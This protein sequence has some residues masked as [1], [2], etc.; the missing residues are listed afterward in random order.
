MYYAR[1]QYGNRWDLKAHPRKELLEKLGYK[2]ASKMYRDLEGG[3]TS[4]VGY[5]IGPHWVDVH[6]LVPAFESVATDK[7]VS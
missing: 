5:V 6:K 3:G 4:H 2:K 7:E 1:D